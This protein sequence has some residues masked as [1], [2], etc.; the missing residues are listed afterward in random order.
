MKIDTLSNEQMDK[1]R[2]IGDLHA[3]TF[4]R[5]VVEKSELNELNI[6]FKSLV[7]NTQLNKDIIPKPFLE[8]IDSNSDLP[9]WANIEMIELA[10]QAFSRVGPAFVIAYFCKSL[11]EC[12]ACGKGAEVLFKTGRLTDHTRRRVAQTAQ[13]VLDVMS[14]GGLE[15]GGR[16][17]IAALK[18]RLMHASIRY[19]FIK[20]LDRGNIDYSI[21]KS[22]LPINQ[23]DLLGTMLAFSVVVTEGMNKLGFEIT[24]EENEAILHLWK[25]VGF[26]IGIDEKIMPIDCAAANE[27]WKSIITRHFENTT[28]GSKLA[29]LL[30]NMLDEILHESWLQDIIPL[31]MYKLM[32]N[33]TCQILD[34]RKPQIYNPLAIITFI[35]GLFLLKFEN[36]GFIS[37]KI[38][39]Y[40]NLTILKRLE[41]FIAEG[42]DT[43]I[44]IPPS[45]RKDWNLDS[46]LKSI[47][48]RNK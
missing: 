18:V 34:V 6:M 27:L 9:S 14:P 43:G 35:F 7:Y 12:Y 41:L 3:D 42:E 13:F 48:R 39:Q 30:V 40:I 47:F 33:Q 15:K 23:E 37:R 38:S 8:Y 2:Q 46:P 16:G 10:Q 5:E 19:Y 17:I 1:L 44:Y 22:G 24:K 45:L 32:G 4:I 11:P 29:N 26:L 31:I 21:D 20:E 25:C 28:A 36:S